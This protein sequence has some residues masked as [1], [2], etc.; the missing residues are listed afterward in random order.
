M[1]AQQFE[2]FKSQRQLRIML[3]GGDNVEELL[4]DLRAIEGIRKGSIT[5]ESGAVTFSY[6][7]AKVSPEGILAT[8]RSKGY[9]K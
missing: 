1:A 3:S 6:H 7:K 8:L 4:I 5:I 9:L 2:R